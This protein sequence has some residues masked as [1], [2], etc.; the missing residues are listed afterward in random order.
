[1]PQQAGRPTSPAPRPSPALASA[2]GTALQ[3]RG[4][5]RRG[6]GRVPR[7]PEAFAQGCA[8]ATQASELGLGRASPRPQ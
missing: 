7:P 3:G 8:R 5:P 4:G 6:K 2:V 1:M